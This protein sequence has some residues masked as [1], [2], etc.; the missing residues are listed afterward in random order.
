MSTLSNSPAIVPLE[1]LTLIRATGDDAVEFLHGQFSQKIR[2]LAGR[3]RAAGY[4]SP[5][6]RLLAVM[7]AFSKPAETTDNAVYLLLP[8]STAPGFLKRLRMYVLRAKVTFELVEP[9]PQMIAAIGESGA[10]QLRA[11][12]LPVPQQG[13]CLS[14]GDMVLLGLEP[15]AAIDGFSQGGARVLVIGK[16]LPASLIEAIAEVPSA[17]WRASELAAGFPQV[18]PETLDRFV[19]QAANLELVGGVVFDKG[20]YP[21]QEVVSRVQ[22]IGETK[23]RAALEIFPGDAP[24]AGAPVYFKADEAG[25]VVDAVAINDRALVFASASLDAIEGGF[26]L[27]SEGAAGQKTPLPYV[28]R[29]VLER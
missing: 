4:C 5:K 11:A 19:P 20:C 1:G 10:A 21:G 6:G 29:N 28:Y 7:R 23:R 18:Y 22:H 24:A 15:S 14:A 26:S 27:S 2:G 12:G 16:N 9:A 17:Y 25:A 3:V 13:E 8:S